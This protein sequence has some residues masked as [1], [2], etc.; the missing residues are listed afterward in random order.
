MTPSTSTTLQATR[1]RAD[2]FNAG[3]LA[4]QAVV[5]LALAYRASEG[6]LPAAA[7]VAVALASAF[8][9][10]QAPGAAGTRHFNAVALMLVAAIL[11]HVGKGALELHF[12]VFVSLAILLAYADWSVLVV[13]AVTI[14]AHHVL[15]SAAQAAGWGVYVMP[16]PDWWRVAGHA[17][18]VVVETVVLVLLARPLQAALLG[19]EA[20]QEF[21]EKARQGDFSAAGAAASPMHESI[22]AVR[23]TIGRTMEQVKGVAV[24]LD[25]TAKTLADR[26]GQ[27]GDNGSAQRD[28]VSA[29]AASIEQL[30]TA[31]AS[32]TEQAQSLEVLAA[33]ARQSAHDS[34]T[35]VA[36]AAR[37]MLD[38][39]GSVTRS[40]DLMNDLEQRSGQVG[41]VVQVITSI[42]EQTNLLALNAAIEAARA[43]ESGRGFSVV[44]DEVRSLAEQ[45]KGATT[46]ISTIIGQM[47]QSRTQALEAVRSAAELAGHGSA[48]ASAASES[49]KGMVSQAETVGA[50]ASD[51]LSALSGQQQAASVVAR[52]IEKVSIDA[53]RST[54]AIREVSGSA[55]VL[56]DLARSLV[57]E[58]ARIRTARPA[59][60]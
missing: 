21:A 59:A 30:T 37:A 51:M 22:E 27:L 20:A 32:L 48:R 24:R 31:V 40:L 26:S 17:A 39:S 60:A 14:A 3:I 11:I 4:L 29:V 1:A 5:G 28:A 13:A 8:L 52:S 10:F 41:R 54:E 9:A 34:S 25:E 49:M 18:Y 56:A 57:E 19:A 42:A 7:A 46:E 15:L 50:T 23:R 38:T 35:A 43:G 16:A 33:Q 55:S 36:E 45:T 6:W 44:A 58:T 12:A 47:E 2:A 53:E